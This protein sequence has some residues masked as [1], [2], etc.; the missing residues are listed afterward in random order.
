MWIFQQAWCH[1]VEPSYWG[2]YHIVEA[3]NK[4]DYT[5]KRGQQEI[6]TGSSYKLR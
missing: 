1:D 5:K 6:W 4:H 3:T 2:Y